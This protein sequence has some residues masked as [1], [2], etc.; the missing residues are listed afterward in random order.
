MCTNDGTRPVDTTA[1]PSQPARAPEADA[2]RPTPAVCMYVLTALPA[3]EFVEGRR[4]S[5]MRRVGGVLWTLV[6]LWQGLDEF[7]ANA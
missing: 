5:G 2:R 4:V 7:I 1:V 3:L 6:M